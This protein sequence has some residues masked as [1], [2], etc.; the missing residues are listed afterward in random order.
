[1]TRKQLPLRRAD[2][3]VACGASLA[4]GTTATWDSVARTVT[5]LPCEKE[6][7]LPVDVGVAGRSAKTKGEHLRS[8]QEARRKALKERHPILGRVGLAIAGPANAGS[9]WLKGAVGEQLLGELLESLRPHGVLPLHDRRIPR[10]SANIDHLAVTPNGVWVIDTKTY[11]GEVEVSDKGGWFRTDLHLYVN[12][13]D[14]TSF[15]TGIHRQRH[16]VIEALGPAFEGVPVSAALCFVNADWPWFA[17]S[18][19]VDGVVITWRKALRTFLIEDTGFD[20]DLRQAV[21]R[22]LA[23]ALPAKR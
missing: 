7:D 15:I 18:K 10:S 22:H 4:V 8:A 13:R 20:E 19:T 5:C 3:C 6:V 17:R 9:S 1:M 23:H 16:K 11:D 2:T 21:H 14:K 12:G